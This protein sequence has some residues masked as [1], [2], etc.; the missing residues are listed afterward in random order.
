MV[1]EQFKGDEA[2]RVIGRLIHEMKKL[3]SNEKVIPVVSAEYRKA[4]K[5]W[6][7]DLSLIHI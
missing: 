1:L 4:N 7:L 5:G 6:T 3:Y 2:F